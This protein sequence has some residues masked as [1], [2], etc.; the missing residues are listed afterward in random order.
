MEPSTSSSEGALRSADNL[1]SN[2]A[3][4]CGRTDPESA[5]PDQIASGST[6]SSASSPPACSLPAAL[7]D[8][9]T[10]PPV[11]PLA[12]SPLP[13]S[14]SASPAMVHIEASSKRRRLFLGEDW[15]EI[16]P[17]G[18]GC[19]VGRS[20]VI[21]R[22]KG[23]TVMFDCG[24]HPAYSGLGALPIFD[25]VDMTSVDVCLITHF[26][27][28]HCG[29]LPYLV[30][31]TAFR[32]RVFMTE[33]TR[34]ISKLVWLDY[35]RMSAFSQAPEQANAAASQRAS[36]GQGDKSGAGN[37]LYDED[38]VDKTV[39]MAEC[40]DFHQ[41]VE[42]GGVK[43]S[44][45]GAGHVLG[46]CMF[47]IEIGGVRMLY[48]GDFSREKDRHVPIAEVPPVDVQLLICES[49][50]GIHVHDDRQLRERRF[51]KAVVDIVLNR[52]GKCLL[53]VFALGRAQ[54]LL[55]ILEEYWTAH[56]EVCH[57][58]ILFLSPLSSKCMVVFDAFV[59]MCGDA[60]R[61]R[62]LRGE[63]PFAFRFVKNLKSVESARVYIHHDGPAVIMAAPG[64]LQSGASR[65]IFE[66]LA[67]ESKNGVIL[68]GYSVKGT[69]ADELKR[70][71][72][73][74]Q[75]PD[76]VLR[77]RCSFEMISFSA[78]SD[79]QQT[80]DF[81][82]KLKVPNV[83]LVH[84]ERGEMRRLKE[85][86]EEERP[87]LCVFTPEILQK[88]SLQ[89]TPSRCVVAAGK[90][91]DDIQRFAECAD[92]GTQPAESVEDAAGKR[93]VA[94]G[95]SAAREAEGSLDSLQA[96]ESPEAEG[97]SGGPSDTPAKN[98]PSRGP[99]AAQVEGVIVVQE[100]QQ[101]LL[102]YP[103]DLTTNGRIPVTRLRQKLRLPFVRPL[104]TLRQALLQIFEDIEDD[105]ALESPAGRSETDD[106]WIGP[107]GERKSTAELQP[108]LENGENTCDD[109]SGAEPAK[110]TTKQTARI[111]GAS[112]VRE[113]SSVQKDQKVD[114]DAHLVLD[115]APLSDR[116][117]V[118]GDA[119]R[120]YRHPRHREEIVVEW[121][122]GPTADL[123]ADS[124]SF[125]AVDLMR[126]PSTP[127]EMIFSS[128][129]AQSEAVIVDVL[130]S[131]LERQFGPVQVVPASLS[132]TEGASKDARKVKSEKELGAGD[133]SPQGEDGLR[134][135]QEEGNV[136]LRF[137]VRDMGGSAGAAASAED[138]KGTEK[139]KSDEKELRKA[140]EQDKIPVEI[141][142]AK[143]IVRCKNQELR[144]KIHA[145]VRR[146]EGA[147]LPLP[148]S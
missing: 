79:Y 87:A 56:P 131:H 50:Y 125:L 147:L 77:R 24:V 2:P 14:A 29:A 89:F 64:M 37:Y 70:E 90:L 53:P 13:A 146:I 78:H 40:L 35:A 98:A 68:T 28:D 110:D 58:P 72:E 73:T 124:V 66:A 111:A 135:A 88:V 18:A 133:S 100:G 143:R 112:R 52:G 137:S 42:V 67:P 51:L 130:V 113:V 140:E 138:S 101:P 27:L 45:F 148:L 141:D 17:L 116:G 123:I 19:E 81:I 61:N 120:V 117:F 132:D 108:A 33:P 5:Q 145:M 12:S 121:L 22:Y 80:Q 62:A 21:V 47:L 106:A 85:K 128:R 9:E 144:Q 105:E 139:E 23:V 43:I 38:D 93:G 104:G 4:S 127:E 16:T 26:H 54:E 109:T 94:E 69:L 20:C 59:D 114:V 134:K 36:S 97:A 115:D 136:L 119:V 122:T 86:L 63:N 92:L 103:E 7:P 75:L 1:P 91:A 30:T 126:L 15:V 44:C 142:M 6:P 41:Q 57:V 60:V 84:G 95:G 83:V 82:G 129:E 48:T 118:V 49:T 11:L 46:A 32:G 34:V 39:Q 71:P 74:I 25:A 96:P 31:K 76:R 99:G 10:L 65:E 55:L 8:P 102:L 3:P 107:E